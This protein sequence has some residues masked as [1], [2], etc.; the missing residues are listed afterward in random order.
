[1]NDSNN[2]EINNK[3]YK[4]GNRYE[5]R[6]LLYIILLIFLILNLFCSPFN[7]ENNSNYIIN[8][9]NEKKINEPNLNINKNEKKNSPLKVEKE[10]NDIKDKKEDNKNKNKNLNNNKIN[11]E[12]N[13]EIIKNNKK[14]MKYIN[15]NTKNFFQKFEMFSLFGFI[16]ILY[17]LMWHNSNKLEEERNDEQE[18]ESL[19]YKNKYNLLKDYE[20][21][22]YYENI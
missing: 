1:M 16:G 15:K 17:I 5:N 3:N 6:K 13:N 11:K 2:K 12:N 4:E 7:N 14:K 21:D 22:D 18:N 9:I 8:N 20:E 19:K 10:N